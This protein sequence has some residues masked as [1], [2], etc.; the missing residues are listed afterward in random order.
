MRIQEAMRPGVGITKGAIR[1]RMASSNVKCL[2]RCPSGSSFA[3]ARTLK[4]RGVIGFIDAARI[5]PDSHP[6]SFEHC[7]ESVLRFQIFDNVWWQN[8][9]DVSYIAKKLESRWVGYTQTEGLWKSWHNI[10]TLVGGAGMISE[11]VNA[12]DAKSMWRNYEIMRPTSREPAKLLT[13][14]NSPHNTTLGFAAQRPYGDFAVYNLYNVTEGTKPL[15]LDFKEAGLP[16][17]VNCAV[18][19]FWENKVIGYATDS[20]TTAPFEHLYS[21]LLRFTPITSDRPTLVGSDLHLSIGATEIDNL[22]VAKSSITIDLN[23]EAG[24]QEG[25]LTLHSTKVLAVG[26]SENCDVTSVENLGENLWKVN[27]IGRQ[28]GKKQLVTLIVK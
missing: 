7:L 16:Q 8:D 6:A 15:T 2:R 27:L 26:E 18:Y 10:V 17:G 1:G 4:A 22:R 5:G 19:D 12:D 11:P 25:S 23:D 9:S 21:A 3:P 24:A 28:W 20:Y 13:L 14:G